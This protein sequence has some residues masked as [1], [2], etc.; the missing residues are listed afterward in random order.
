MARLPKHS[1]T[2]TTSAR[3]TLMLISSVLS[4][5]RGES[6][7][8]RQRSAELAMASRAARYAAGCSPSR[9]RSDSTR[10]AGL[11]AASRPPVSRPIFSV[12]CSSA[13]VI[14]WLTE[15][16]LGHLT[17]GSTPD[18]R[19]HANRRLDQRHAEALDTGTV[20]EWLVTSP[21]MA[22]QYSA[23]ASFHECSWLKALAR[24]ASESR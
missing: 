2:T 12:R 17:D 11:G 13:A 19:P 5:Q 10:G 18:W 8:H 16:R 22:R 3:R 24:V 1:A 23:A 15:L 21:S 20:A 4:F 7:T 14:R 6:G 9:C